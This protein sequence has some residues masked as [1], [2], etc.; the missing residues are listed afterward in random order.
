MKLPKNMEY[1]LKGRRFPKSPAPSLAM[2]FLRRQIVG[3]M[4]D[5]SQGVGIG[6]LLAQPNPNAVSF[7]QQTIPYTANNLGNWTTPEEKPYN[8]AT[9]IEKNLITLLSDLYGCPRGLEGYVSSGA[10]EGNIFMAW[11]GRNLLRSKLKSSPICMLKTDLA[12]YSLSK[13]ADIVGVPAHTIALDNHTW[14]MSPEDLEKQIDNL[15]RK[16]MRGF[17][18]PLTLGY[19]VGGTS[20]DTDSLIAALKRCKKRLRNLHFFVWTDA[21]LAGLVLPFAQKNFRPFRHPEIQAFIVDFHKFA[22]VPLPAGVILYR[23]GLRKHVEKTIPYLTQKDNTLLGSRSGIAAISIWGVIHAQGHEGFA[24]MVKACLMEKQKTLAAILKAEPSVRVI[25][26]PDSIQAALT[27]R[28]PLPPAL[29]SKYGI[30]M[31]TYPLAIG[32]K[33]KTFRLYKLFFL[34]RYP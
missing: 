3:G 1:I 23:K 34:P 30:V 33:K 6:H 8:I 10:T 27:V 11:C 14:S 2:L 25:T 17:L 18:I 7:W 32:G 9:A 19:T 22:G 26:A 16:G 5:Y 24:G 12:H 21:A 20:D 4:R 15:Y 29:C 31:S 13:A 28:K